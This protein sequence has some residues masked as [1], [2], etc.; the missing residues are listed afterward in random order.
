MHGIWTNMASVDAST[1]FR[2]RRTEVGARGLEP[3]TSALSGLRSN[4]LSYAPGVYRQRMGFCIPVP[5]HAD[6]AW[7]S[8]YCWQC[9]AGETGQNETPNSR[10]A[11]L[12]VKAPRTATRESASANTEDRAG[13]AG[14]MAAIKPLLSRHPAT[15][16]SVA[17]TMRFSGQ[18]DVAPPIPIHFG[19]SRG[20]RC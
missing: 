2:I 12:F 19:Q 14:S 5:R 18:Q 3:R 15:A 8:A 1:L 7:Q 20:S 6:R 10:S 11:L 9:S 16:C 13:L 17:V 4:Q